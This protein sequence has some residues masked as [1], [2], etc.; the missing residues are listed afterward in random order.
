MAAQYVLV[1]STP[2]QVMGSPVNPRYICSGTLENVPA[3]ELN[4]SELSPEDH[5]E[6]RELIFSL[7]IVVFGVL[8]LKKVLFSR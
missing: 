6:Y 2:W 7:F 1:C 8:V 3:N 5:A 4:S